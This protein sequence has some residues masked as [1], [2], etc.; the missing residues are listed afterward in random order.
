MVTDDVVFILAR[1]V[2]WLGRH[3]NWMPVLESDRS[4]LVGHVSTHD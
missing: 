2:W 4:G 3:W 1:R